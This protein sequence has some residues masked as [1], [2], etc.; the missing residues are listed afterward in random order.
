MR[1]INH[2]KIIK[3]GMATS[4][5]WKETLQKVLFKERIHVEVSQRLKATLQQT[6]HPIIKVSPQCKIVPGSEKRW[7]KA[8]IRLVSRFSRL[9]ADEVS[10]K[11]GKSEWS[12]IVN[13]F[14]IE[15]TGVGLVKHI[16]GENENTQNIDIMSK[17]FL[18]TCW[19]TIIKDNLRKPVRL[20]VCKF[21]R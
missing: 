6:N 2:R 12:R 4:R 8:L 7:L 20:G 16:V 9:M 3:T 11:C 13:C 18:E 5:D 14:G 15:T 10:S 19:Y 1:R 17:G 21:L